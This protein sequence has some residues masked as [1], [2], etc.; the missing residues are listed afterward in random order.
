M[1]DRVYIVSCGRAGLFT[2]CRKE[3]I[4]HNTRILEIN[5]SYFLISGFQN[6]RKEVSVVQLK[7]TCPGNPKGKTDTIVEGKPYKLRAE[8]LKYD[9]KDLIIFQISFYTFLILRRVTYNS[10]KDFI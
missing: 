1:E 5:I 2:T 7:V 9:R 3:Y 6:S 10:N 8:V 4:F